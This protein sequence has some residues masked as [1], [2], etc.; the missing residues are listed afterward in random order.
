MFLS[1]YQQSVC[2]AAVASAVACA[3]LALHA[4]GRDDDRT[5]QRDDD[6]RVKT[7]FVVAM[8]NHNWTQAAGVTN[9]QQIFMNPAAPFTNSLVNGA[10][11]IS[12]QVAY[13]NGYINAGIG[14]HPSEPN[15]IWAEAG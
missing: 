15:Y 2:A 6:S 8:E 13:A 12:G 4:K 10:S 9:P 5:E 7:V 14:V 1:K 3:G 11:G